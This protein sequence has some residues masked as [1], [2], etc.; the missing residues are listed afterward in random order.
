[1]DNGRVIELEKELRVAG[2]GGEAREKLS[3]QD[4]ASSYV[5]V[6]EAPPNEVRERAGL[7]IPTLTENAS[8]RKEVRAVKYARRTE[9]E[10]PGH[11]HEKEHEKKPGQQQPGQ[12]GQQQPGQ[13]QPGQQHPGQ[14]KK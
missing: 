14:E 9:H 10:G 7:P 4:W 8:G 2:G 5:Y 6:P 12:P 1:M 13:H 3:T 11:E